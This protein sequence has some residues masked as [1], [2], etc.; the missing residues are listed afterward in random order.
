MPPDPLFITWNAIRQHSNE[1]P[2]EGAGDKADSKK[3]GLRDRAQQACHKQSILSTP[4]CAPIAA[5]QYLQTLHVPSNLAG[6]YSTY[7]P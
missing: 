6:Q 1:T 3:H 7:R 5:V 2:H 4:L